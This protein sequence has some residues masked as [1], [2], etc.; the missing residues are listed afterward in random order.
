MYMET[1][2]NEETFFIYLSR[3]EYNEKKNKFLGKLKD[4]IYISENIFK[5]SKVIN[6][7]LIPNKRVCTFILSVSF[8][9]AK[10]SF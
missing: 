7:S 2:E 6:C 4:K 5:M 8:F 3:N 9:Q 10:C 1:V